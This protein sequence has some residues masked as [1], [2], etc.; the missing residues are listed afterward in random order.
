MTHTLR[1]RVCGR[2]F[3]TK[4]PAAHTC[5]RA[6]KREAW[7]DK[8][9]KHPFKP[10]SIVT[11]VV[12]GA[13][14]LVQWSETR[15]IDGVTREI[16]RNAHADVLAIDGADADVRVEGEVRRVAVASLRPAANATPVSYTWRANLEGWLA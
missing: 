6:C 16:E 2:E 8:R 7:N 10:L 4:Y 11:Q 12:T 5:S 3:V 9:R 14:V 13:R 1:C 15:T